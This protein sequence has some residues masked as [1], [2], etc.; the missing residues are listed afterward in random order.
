MEGFKMNQSSFDLYP[1][2]INAMTDAVDTWHRIS[3][4]TKAE[5]RRIKTA[6]AKEAGLSAFKTFQE[7]AALRKDFLDSI[8]STSK[9]DEISKFLDKFHEKIELYYKFYAQ[10]DFL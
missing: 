7:V 10:Y 5:F 8:R 6:E 4:A 1:L 9:P 3:E 2:A